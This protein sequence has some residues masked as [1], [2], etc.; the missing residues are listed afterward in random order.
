MSKSVETFGNLVF[1]E[2]PLAEINVE[3][4]SEAERLTHLLTPTVM[5]GVTELTVLRTNKQKFYQLDALNRRLWLNLEN[6]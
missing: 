4:E 2:N 1:R 3:S 6:E 5:N